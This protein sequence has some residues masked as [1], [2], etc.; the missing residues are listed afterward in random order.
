MSPSRDPR[1]DERYGHKDKPYASDGAASSDLEPDMLREIV[2]HTASS[3]AKPREIDPAIKAAMIEVAR[4]YA[5]QPMTVDPAGAALLEAVLRI[6]FPALAERP[7]LLARTARTV[8]NS[9]LADPAARLRVEH[10][11][12]TLAEDAA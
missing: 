11:W 10:L 7:P 3:L 5:G 4:T 8:A 9:L 1:R 6:Q 2:A 12:A